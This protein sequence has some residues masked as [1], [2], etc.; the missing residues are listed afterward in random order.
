MFLGA[1][2]STV[3]TRKLIKGLRDA[4]PDHAAWRIQEPTNEEMYRVR[5]LKL[6]K[7]RFPEAFRHAILTRLS[8]EATRPSYRAQGVR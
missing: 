7:V 8:A 2:M 6:G 5:Y 1:T 3:A 4:N